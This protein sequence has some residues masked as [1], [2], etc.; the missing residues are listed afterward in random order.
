M[1]CSRYIV[2]RMSIKGSSLNVRNKLNYQ[3][4]RQVWRLMHCYKF[5]KMKILLLFY[6]S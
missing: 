2:S 4:Y 1:I 6:L 3:K 5:P